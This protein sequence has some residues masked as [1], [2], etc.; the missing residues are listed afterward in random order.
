MVYFRYLLLF[1]HSGVQHILRCVF[2]LFFFIYVASFSELSIL[3][4]PSV[5]SNVFLLP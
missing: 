4:G 3:I 5:F 2:V 1:V